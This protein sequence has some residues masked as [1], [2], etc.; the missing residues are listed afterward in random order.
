M[1][2]SYVLAQWLSKRGGMGSNFGPA[3]FPF[4]QQ[5][6]CY[7]T[8]YEALMCQSF[9]FLK[10]INHTSLYAIASDAV[11]IQIHKFVRLPCW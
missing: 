2:V 11:L 8:L 1:R 4:G 3:T 5:L 9:V 6:C 7:L 10:S